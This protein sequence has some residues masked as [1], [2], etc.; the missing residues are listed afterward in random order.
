MYVLTIFRQDLHAND[1][2]L[3][4]ETDLLQRYV[5]P[6]TPP[7]LRAVVI[8]DRSKTND[9]NPTIATAAPV[10]PI[11]T[12]STTATAN[13]RKS[14]RGV[15]PRKNLASALS[16][17]DKVAAKLQQRQFVDNK[18][19]DGL[20]GALGA[21]TQTE[22]SRGAGARAGSDIKDDEITRSLPH[23]MVNASGRYGEDGG[24]SRNIAK[25]YDHP[26]STHQKSL[27]ELLKERKKVVYTIGKST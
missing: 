2:I 17:M 1:I 10:K 4:H 11:T 16:G 26:R 27:R 21:G 24:L 8:L 14:S 5:S 7:S 18:K 12:T 20:S 3:Q 13:I 23:G 19:G 6:D 22:S 25:I 9:S 15:K